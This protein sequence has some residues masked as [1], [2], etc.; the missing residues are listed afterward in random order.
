MRKKQRF[1]DLSVRF[2]ICLWM[3]ALLAFSIGLLCSKKTVTAD[4]ASE[5]VVGDNTVNLYGEDSLIL[6]FVPEQSGYYMFTS[7]NDEMFVSIELWDAEQFADGDYIA[8]VN[9]CY[10]ASQRIM[11]ELTADETY[12]LV[13][14]REGSEYNDEFDGPEC[15]YRY[16]YDACTTNVR[17]VSYC[18][19]TAPNSCGKSAT[20]LF[21][22]GS[23]TLTISGTGEIYGCYEYF[24]NV[25]PWASIKDEVH[26]IVIDDGITSI[27]KRAFDGFKNLTS[28]EIPDSITSVESGAFRGCT[29]LS[30]IT[31]PDS[32]KVI[33]S[34]AFS[35]CSS[36][37]T[38]TIPSCVEK[39]GMGAF[40]NCTGLTNAT[41][42]EG[43]KIIAPRAFYGCSG[44]TDIVVPQSV[45][46][47]GYYA[48]QEC[49]SL[50]NATIRGEILESK[51]VWR[52]KNLRTV[53]LGVKFIG[54]EAFYDC[55]SLDDLVLED[56]VI[57]IVSCAFG[58]CSKL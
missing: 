17:I 7:L 13:F 11:A 34:G 2:S 27:G 54:H 30:A 26:S 25:V 33:G 31:L 42:S 8:K 47:I 57:D 24:D 43:V 22:S 5:L 1:F 40:Y 12:V 6:A 39:I 28:V 52:C 10:D 21:D 16:D 45:N 49:T 14:K 51:S 41:I 56:G 3:T 53:T 19:E 48:F 50:K 15:V 20:W 36:L 44:L 18:E 32:V 58:D 38:I 55:T 9:R 35:S 46:R 37:L 4:T 23:G 29:S